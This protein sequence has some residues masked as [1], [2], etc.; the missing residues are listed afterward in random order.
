MVGDQHERVGTGFG[1]VT[2]ELDGHVV[3]ATTLD[4]LG[5][6]H[7]LGRCSRGVGNVFLAHLDLH[8]AQVTH[9]GGVR[10]GDG[11]LGALGGVHHAGGALA[12]LA[13]VLGRPCLVRLV[14]PLLG[15]GNVEVVGEVLG[16]ARVV[17]AVHH[18]DT[19]VGEVRSRVLLGD[20]RSVPGADLALEDLGN[21]GCVQLQTVHAGQVEGH[22]DR[23]D[24]HGQVQGSVGAALLLGFLVLLVT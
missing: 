12:V 13:G 24:V 3:F 7:G 2:C 19:G 22:G 15:S 6:L 4:L 18:G 21:G 5:D 17:V 1:G 20:L 14:G 23:G 16:G 9:G 10:V 8:G 11:A